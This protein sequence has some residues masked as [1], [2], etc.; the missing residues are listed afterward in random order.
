MDAKST[1]EAQ[2]AA[3]VLLMHRTDPA[4]SIE[5][6]ASHIF[7]RGG[8]L[9]WCEP[10]HLDPLGSASPALHFVNL[11]GEA[12]IYPDRDII[13]WATTGERDLAISL[14]EQGREVFEWYAIRLREAGMTHAEMRAVVLAEIVEIESDAEQ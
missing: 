9:W 5:R 7:V 4:R 3:M 12:S 11:S 14:N 8:V 1:L 6:P 13:T 10:Q 2:T